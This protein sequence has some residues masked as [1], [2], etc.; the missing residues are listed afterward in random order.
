MRKE[1][2]ALA[3]DR[4][5]LSSIS[6]AT[7]IVSLVFALVLIH[8]LRVGGKEERATTTTRRSTSFFVTTSARTR[9]SSSAI[10]EAFHFPTLLPPSAR[11]AL[12]GSKE[13]EKLERDILRHCDIHDGNKKNEES[14]S[15][16]SSACLLFCPDVKESWEVCPPLFAAIRDGNVYYHK[17]KKVEMTRGMHKSHLAFPCVQDPNV[18]VKLADVINANC[19]MLG[20]VRATVELYPSAPA[21]LLCLRFSLDDYDG[22]HQKK[23]EEKT[24][25][26]VT[27]QSRRED[28]KK[29]AVF[30]TE[31]WV[32]QFLGRNKLCPYTASSRAAAVGLTDVGV[33]A[34][35]V[36]VRVVLSTAS[37]LS[38]H[39]SNGNMMGRSPPDIPSPPASTALVAAF[40]EST[41]EMLHSTEQNISTILLAAPE[42]DNHFSSFCTVCDE[43]IE[44]TIVATDAT[45]VIGRAWFHPHYDANMI[46]HDNVIPGHAIPHIMV[47]EFINKSRRE[48]GQ[49][50]QKQVMDNTEDQQQ[51]QQQNPSI[52]QL[53]IDDIANANNAVRKTPHA[54]IN[55][56]RR[57]QLLAAQRHELALPDAQRP[58]PND[59][60]VRNVIRLASKFL[61]GIIKKQ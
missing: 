3:T 7:F 52:P 33:K 51:Q 32:D 1:Y 27:E 47:K 45:S 59:V 43:I 54:T 15:S 55:I 18:L 58:P 2:S 28:A 30:A 40:W 48:Q 46:G 9:S 26:A 35:P 5:L 4:S 49:H 22:N 6:S 25:P 13:L 37:Q 23:E 34:G 42:Y 8:P 36:A 39:K 61:H 44:P 60:Y 29:S 50:Q 10:V 31:A 19:V 14:S 41:K 57:T 56:L 20:G 53:T 38:N 24:A 17:D 11:L 16:S 21:P 12:G